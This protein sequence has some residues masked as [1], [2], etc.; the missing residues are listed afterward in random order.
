MHTGPSATPTWVSDHI[1]IMLVPADHPLMESYRPTQKAITVWP[2]D[3]D[4]FQ[5]TD[6]QVFRDAVVWEG[7]FEE[8]TSVVFT[9]Q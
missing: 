5:C 3:A 7:G 4:C 1:Y 2:S 9:Y 6:W 8:Y